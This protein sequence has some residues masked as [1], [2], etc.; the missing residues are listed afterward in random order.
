[1]HHLLIT[2]TGFILLCFQS[3]AIAKVDSAAIQDSIDATSVQGDWVSTTDSSDHIR[4]MVDLELGYASLQSVT[5]AK[6]GL[7]TRGYSFSVDSNG[8]LDPSGMY[9]FWG[10]HHCHVRMLEPGLLEVT[11]PEAMGGAVQYKELESDE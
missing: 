2:L 1:M 3:V 4:F 6:N 7:H 5:Q 11:Y 8:F 9:V 10:G